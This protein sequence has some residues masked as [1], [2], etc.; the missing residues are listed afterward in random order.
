M[1]EWLEQYVEKVM[2]QQKKQ[3]KIFKKVKKD[4]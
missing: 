4:E 2:A 3:N 1:D